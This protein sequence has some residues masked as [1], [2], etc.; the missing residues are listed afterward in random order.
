MARI[1]GIAG[2]VKT[3]RGSVDRLSKVVERSMTIYEALAGSVETLRPYVEDLSRFYTRYAIL[4][5]QLFHRS[6]E[7]S[8]LADDI[9]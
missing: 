5:T 4:L 6:A 9:D 8:Q 2:R 1:A 3:C 7:I